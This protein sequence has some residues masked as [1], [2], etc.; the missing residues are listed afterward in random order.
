MVAAMPSR[1]LSGLGAVR[2]GLFNVHE[3]SAGRFDGLVES[4][5]EE[6]ILIEGATLWD[7]TLGQR[8]GSLVVDGGRISQCLDTDEPVDRTDGLTVI[9]ATG[10]FV[11]PGLIDAHVHMLF[12]G[13]ASLL[14]NPQSLLR[15]WKVLR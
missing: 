7:E 10:G 14:K 15:E 6:R 13:D 5:I 11:M 12:D 9:D 8:P 1:T 2:R 4:P 3:G